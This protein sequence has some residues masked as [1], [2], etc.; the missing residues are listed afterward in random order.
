V[1]AAGPGGGD[2][3]PAIRNQDHAGGAHRGGDLHLRRGSRQ[4]QRRLGEGVDPLQPALGDVVAER[5]QATLGRPPPVGGVDESHQGT[6]V[7]G[8]VLLHT[9]S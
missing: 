8:G 7:H 4:L 9:R 2:P 5:G 1:P 6:A 3:D